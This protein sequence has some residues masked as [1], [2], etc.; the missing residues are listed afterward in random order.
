MTSF[1][2]A[3]SDHRPSAQTVRD[4]LRLRGLMVAAQDGDRTAYE[5]LL[6]ACLPRIRTVALRQG[7]EVDLLDDIAQDV[8]ITIHRARQT[9]DPARPFVVWLTMIVRRR[10]I[11]AMRRRWRH[12]AHE[13]HAPELYDGQADEHDDTGQIEASDTFDRVKD[14]LRQL[15]LAQREAVE[16]L[17][18][19]QETLEEASK[20]TGRGLGALKVN[21]HRGL[22]AL[23]AFLVDG[24]GKS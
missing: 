9:Y 24:R 10:T 16:R 6:K 22:K 2:D 12:T 15:P 3:R 8:L 23:R 4:D 13:V 18:L 1:M 21:L 20:A 11:D 5:T 17:S 19:K 7:A 14:A